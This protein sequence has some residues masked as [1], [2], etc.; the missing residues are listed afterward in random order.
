MQL[1]D[2]ALGGGVGG[3]FV[4]SD[5]EQAG[6]AERVAGRT[7][8]LAPEIADQHEVHRVPQLRLG[9]SLELDPIDA[10]GAGPARFATISP[11]A[12]AGATT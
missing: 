7:L 3:T 9:G 4:G 10:P 11:V 1:Q 12:R 5:A 6:G 8:A 2:L